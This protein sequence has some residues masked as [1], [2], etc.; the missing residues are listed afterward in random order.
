[1]TLPVIYG[2]GSPW[3][4]TRTSTLAEWH[5][6]GTRKNG[7]PCS[8]LLQKFDSKQV[9][10]ETLKKQ[11]CIKCPACGHLNGSLE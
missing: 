7:V 8:R 10:L 2:L 11:N 9:S 4:R 5:C 3:Y 1:M 6:E